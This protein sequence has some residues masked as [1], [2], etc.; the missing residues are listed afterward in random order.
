MDKQESLTDGDGSGASSPGQD[1]EIATFGGGC[2]WCT[3]AVYTEI[4]GV[5][6]VTSG[7]SGGS[8]EHPTYQQVCSGTTGHA[9]CI[10][11]RF[12]PEL[13]SFAQ[14]LEVFFKTHDPT[15]LNRQ[16]A[17]VGTQYRSVIFYHNPQQKEIAEEVI[18]N[19]NKEHAYS[20]SV[21]TQVVPAVT[22]YPAE[23]YHQEYYKNNSRQGYCV[24]V[25]QPKLDKFR[26]AFGDLLKNPAE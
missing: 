6:S 8:V 2:F 14:L 24:Y 9:E 17:D 3:E 1:P 26:A 19:L 21:V 10:Q 18:A 12:D 15:T 13:V 7:Y 23:D 11:I 25:I 20:S 16:G 22:F 4:K 5:L